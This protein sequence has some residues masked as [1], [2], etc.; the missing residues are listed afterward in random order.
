VSV[1]SKE[2]NSQDFCLDFV[3]NTPSAERAE[4]FLLSLLSPSLY[5]YSVVHNLGK[6]AENLLPPANV[7][8]TIVPAAAHS[9]RQKEQEFIIFFYDYESWIEWKYVS[10]IP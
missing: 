7:A 3:H 9:P 4:K 2:L 1:N 6:H 8:D 10:L 5:T